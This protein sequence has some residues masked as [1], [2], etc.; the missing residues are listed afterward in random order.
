MGLGSAGK[1]LQTLQTVSERAEQL[2]AQLKDVRERLTQIE[3]DVD[4][5]TKTVGELETEL[6]EHRVIL[7]ALAEKEGID[8]GELLAD[9]L[10]TEAESPAEAVADA[11]STA[12]DIPVE[13]EGTAPDEGTTSSASTSE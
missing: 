11:D 6:T 7:E 9:E 2:Y 13:E 10:I 8:V 1:M 12:E 4:A 3:N 5:T